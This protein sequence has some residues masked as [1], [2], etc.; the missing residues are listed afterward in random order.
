VLLNEVLH[1]TGKKWTK[2]TVPN[3]GGTGMSDFSTLGSVSCT[4]VTSCVAVGS[5]GSNAV[6]GPRL[7]EVLRW[8]GRKWTVSKV[9]NPDGTVADGTQ[10]LTAVSRQSARGCW[11]VGNYG[12]QEQPTGTLNEALRWNGKKWSQV[13]TPD[14]GGM[15]MHGVSQ[16]FG[17][18]C[19]TS[20]DCWAVGNQVDGGGPFHDMILHWNG[21]KWSVK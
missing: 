10:N 20:T 3:P 17:L 9:P 6:G 1:W 8:D 7:N 13:A 12:D 18:R 5:Y 16:L 2:V 4:A 11:T 21:T 15:T 19:V 14:P